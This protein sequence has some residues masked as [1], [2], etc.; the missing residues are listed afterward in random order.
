MGCSSKKKKKKKMVL[1]V[2]CLFN[3]ISSFPFSLKT[4]KIQVHISMVYMTSK[5]GVSSPKYSELQLYFFESLKN[6]I[7]SV[8][9][10]RAFHSG[11]H[12]SHN[13]CFGTCR[14]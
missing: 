9:A 13:L 5:I 7:S 11:K 1:Y 14:L 2:Y 8:R 4:C 3:Y 10:Q 12:V 6:L